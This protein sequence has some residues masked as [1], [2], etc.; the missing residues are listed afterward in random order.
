MSV[1]SLLVGVA[2]LAVAWIAVPTGVPLYDGI[3]FP[4]EPYRYVVPPAGHKHTPVV[5]NAIGTVFGRHG[6]STEDLDIMSKE[7]GPQA[8]VFV[9]HGRLTGPANARSYQ[10]RIDPVAPSG[11]GIPID[12]NVY[13]VTAACSSQ[14][15]VGGTPMAATPD[16]RITIQPPTTGSYAWMALRATSPRRPGPT[17]LYRATPAAP[18]RSVKTSR[19]GNDIYA[20]TLIS[21]GD[22]A[23]TFSS[24]LPSATNPRASKHHGLP[25]TV[26]VL[27]V[28]LIGLAV[29]ILAIRR[30]RR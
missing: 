12:G 13:R 22:Y 17:F 27:I 30:T 11:S 1:R 9:S 24:D 16:C 3:G 2:A 8:E 10:L 7:Q 6:A 15:V 23:L 21:T 20:T 25:I 4:D 28:I 14:V 19:T 26:I 29:T 5:T 18:W